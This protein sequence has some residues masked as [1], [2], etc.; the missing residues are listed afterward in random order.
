MIIHCRECGKT[1][2]NKLDNCP[3]CNVV[4]M[5]KS[6]EQPSGFSFMQ[7]MLL[8]FRSLFF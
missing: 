1:V 6:Q 4:F 5:I 3:Y 7:K 2:S 8:S